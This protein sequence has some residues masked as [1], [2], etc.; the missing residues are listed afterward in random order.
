MEKNFQKWSIYFSL[1]FHSFDK[2]LFVLIFYS[3]NLSK[4]DMRVTWML[5]RF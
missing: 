3:K 5:I 4:K 2:F 1:L